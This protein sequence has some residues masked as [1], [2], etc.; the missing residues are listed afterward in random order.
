MKARAQQSLKE[1]LRCAWQARS[2][3]A[4]ERRATK[5]RC[6]ALVLALVISESSVCAPP[7]APREATLSLLDQAKRHNDEMA[8]TARDLIVDAADKPGKPGRGAHR[9]WLPAA[10]LRAAFGKGWDHDRPCKRTRPCLA[11]SARA[12]SAALSVHSPLHGI[13]VVIQ[14]RS[15]DGD[16][17]SEVAIDSQSPH[18][19]LRRQLWR[20]GF[21]PAEGPEHGGAHLEPGAACRPGT[22]CRDTPRALDRRGQMGRD[23]HL[24]LCS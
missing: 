4:A 6:C 10:M 5:A 18:V 16:S 19:H 11:A 7:A 15:A 9:V 14:S 20:R 12:S 13:E 21:A 24:R 23:A 1:R 2:R 17:I 3:R 22:A 8:V